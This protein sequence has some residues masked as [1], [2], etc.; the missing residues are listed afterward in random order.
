MERSPRSYSYKRSGPNVKVVG[1]KYS[2]TYN[3]V[4]ALAAKALQVNA[5]DMVLVYSGAI[6][7]ADDNWMIGKYLEDCGVWSNK[8]KMVIGLTENESYGSSSDVNHV[9]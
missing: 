4:K 2:A 8:H 5:K 6:I 1:I 7:S 9:F 3:E